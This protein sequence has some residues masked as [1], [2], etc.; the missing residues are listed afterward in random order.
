MN[1][2]ISTYMDGELDPARMAPVAAALKDSE[3]ARRDWMTYHVIRDA[4]TME[5]PRMDT[6]AARFHERL[7]A[8]PTILAPKPAR[9]R[10]AK[11]QT[12]WLA[13]ASVA[14]VALT[15][16]NS[17]TE[18][19]SSP[20][21]VTQNVA[22]ADSGASIRGNIIPASSIVEANPYVIAHQEYAP[23]TAMEGVAPYIRT[24]SA[25]RQDTAR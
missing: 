23:T 2:D 1:E 15:F 8:E 5:V 22:S 13:A 11:P 3:E 9:T 25:S 24:I 21:L 17:G 4:M 6:F 7:A 10:V 19:P 16:W 12:V 20:N 18:N 14:V